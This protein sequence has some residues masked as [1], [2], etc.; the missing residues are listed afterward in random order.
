MNYNQ[1]VKKKMK[2][3]CSV[4]ANIFFLIRDLGRTYSAITKKRHPQLTQL[5]VY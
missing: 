5:E 2:K 3:K 1:F 4:N